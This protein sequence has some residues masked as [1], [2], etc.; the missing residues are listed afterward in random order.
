MFDEDR[1]AGDTFQFYVSRLRNAISQSPVA[2]EILTFESVN[3]IVGTSKKYIF[4]GE[5]DRGTSY[6]EA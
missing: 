4:N 6:L 5:I 3:D 2:F 1:E